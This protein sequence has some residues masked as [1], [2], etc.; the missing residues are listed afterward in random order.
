LAGQLRL[1]RTVEQFVLHS[2]ALF[3]ARLLLAFL[4]LRS[5]ASTLGDVPGAAAYFGSLGFPAG[6]AVAVMTGLFELVAGGL[7]LVGFK[8]RIAAL[9]LSAFSVLAGAIGHLG[10]GGDDAALAFLHAQAFM[11]D[12]AIA[13]GFMA[14]L[15]AGP[16]GWSVDAKLQQ[17]RD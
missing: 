6:N 3:V 2:A 15:V 16:G 9:A 13:G 1:D 4:F 7:V 5:G 8:A 17:A 12:I 11:K 14:L 10:Q